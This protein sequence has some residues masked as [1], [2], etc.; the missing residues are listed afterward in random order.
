ML[1]TE[2]KDEKRECDNPEEVDFQYDQSGDEAELSWG[3]L[4]IR[5]APS[6]VM[7]AADVRILEL[8]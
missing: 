7:R 4:V 5:S 1:V 6:L 3:N 8:N 2:K